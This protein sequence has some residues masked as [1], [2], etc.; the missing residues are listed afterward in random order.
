MN[1][2]CRCR[3]E[4]P[5]KPFGHAVREA[6]PKC[7]SVYWLWL[8]YEDESVADADEAHASDS[9]RKRYGLPASSPA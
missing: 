4:W 7:G 2:C 8:N 1:R 9:S 6:C 3:Y 5:D